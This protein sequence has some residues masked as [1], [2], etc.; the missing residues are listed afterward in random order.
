MYIQEIGTNEKKFTFIKEK[1]KRK[2]RATDV[3]NIFKANFNFNYCIQNYLE[4]FRRN[5]KYIKEK[6]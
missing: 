1:T 5:I 2:R 6:I 3:I 4:I